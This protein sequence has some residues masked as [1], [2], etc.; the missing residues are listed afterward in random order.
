MQQSET[1]TTSSAS[2][3]FESSCSLSDLSCDN[4]ADNNPDI[5]IQG[6]TTPMI[7]WPETDCKAKP[8]LTKRAKHCETTSTKHVTFNDVPSF[9]FFRAG[10]QCNVTCC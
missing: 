4:A 3:S 8:K 2:S 5:F 7:W 6:T 10:A 9:N 1:L